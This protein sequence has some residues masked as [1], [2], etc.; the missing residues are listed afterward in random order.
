[1]S[2]SVGSIFVYGTLQRG[3][4]RERCWPRRPILIEWATVRGELRD[5]GEYPALVSGDDLILG[6]LWRFN[7]EDLAVTLP[8]LDEIE[9][10]G[11]DDE[12]LYQRRVANCC[13][14]FG[15]TVPALSYWF[16]DP[17]SISKSPI[18][19]PDAEGFCR[20]TAVRPPASS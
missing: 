2:N 11:Q 4:V 3:E 19:Q 18:V 15:E 7:A 20:W 14:L 6:E 17:S 8:V 1:M 12:D 9:W 10:F 13:T 16:A 5:L